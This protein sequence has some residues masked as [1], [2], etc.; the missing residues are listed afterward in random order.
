MKKSILKTE[1]VGIVVISLLG[2]ALHFVF[3]WT[4][5]LAPVG[6]FSPVNESVFEHLKLTFWPTLLY[7]AITYRTLRKSTSNFFIAKAASIY[8]MPAVIIAV[9]YSY[10]GITGTESLAGDILFFIIGVALGQ[11][12]SYKILTREQLPKSIHKLAV[13]GIIAIGVMYILLAY[14]PPHLPF[15]MEHSTGTYGLPR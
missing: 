14:F 15:F 13:A 12:T 7:A 6:I 3:D 5:H 11:I 2:S 9:S 4:G 8:I 10:N 1:L